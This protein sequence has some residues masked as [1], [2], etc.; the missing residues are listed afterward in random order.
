MMPDRHDLVR[1]AHNQA[2]LSAVVEYAPVSRTKLSEITGLS[3][4]TVL[5]IVNELECSGLIRAVGHTSGT[6]GR[7]ALLYEANPAAAV[8]IGVD[9]GGT[10]V[11]AA[12]ADLDG[13][14][15]AEEVARTDHGS[16]A[17]VSQ[18]TQ[19]CQSLTRAAGVDVGALTDLVVGTPGVVSADGTLSLAAN[20]PGAQRVDLASELARRLHVR[21]LVENDVNMA[22]LGEQT[23]GAATGCTNFVVISVGTGVGMG[24]VIDGKLIR[25]AHG[26]A[27]EVGYLPLG[28]DPRSRAARRH[29]ALEVRTGTAGVRAR[30]RQELAGASTGTTRLRP[31][32]SVESVFAAAAEGDP[33]GRAV[34]AAEAELLAQAVLSV[35]SIVDPE[36]VVLAGGIGADPI[37]LDPVRQAFHEMAAVPVRI[38]TAMLGQRS[39]VVGALAMAR[40]LARQRVFATGGN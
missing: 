24:L 11:R 33:V 13:T 37:L 1:A 15:L 4:P 19:M 34:V 6:V 8:V 3:K 20:L 26:S 25:G 23:S 16:G 35:V 12:L 7:S 38:E 5:R 32:S 18:L 10:K 39:G 28:G 22:A 27:G 29:G 9:L 2:V 30:L 40:E 14:V 31:N 17:L 36:V 21:V